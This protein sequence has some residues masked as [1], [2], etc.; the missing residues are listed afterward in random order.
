MPDISRR[1]FLKLA[2]RALL[3]VS[4]LL[5]LGSLVRF[6]GYQSEPDSPTVFD[7][8]AAANYPVGSHTFI[9][10]IPALLQ[11]S[12]SGFT[13][14]SLT[15]THLGCTVQQN[16]SELV[17]PCHKSRFGEAGKILHG[18]AQKPLPALRV[19][20]SPDGQMTLQKS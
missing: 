19:E 1:N 5:G 16:G 13:A 8:G 12:E 17:C 11:H 18:P 10:D 9:P 15:C 14:L 3:T 2:S 7:L 6:L 4:S 20:I